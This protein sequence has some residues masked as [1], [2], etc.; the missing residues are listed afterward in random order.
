M[1]LDADIPLTP[2][3]SRTCPLAT[4]DLRTFA[5]RTTATRNHGLAASGTVLKAGV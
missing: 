5:D 4:G 3:A 2:L 1:D